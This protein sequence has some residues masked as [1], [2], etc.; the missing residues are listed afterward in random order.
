MGMRKTDEKSPD[1]PVTDKPDIEGG[2]TE[3]PSNVIYINFQRHQHPEHI[4]KPDESCQRPDDIVEKVR[5]GLLSRC[6][7]ASARLDESERSIERSMIAV[8]VQKGILKPEDVIDN[9]KGPFVKTKNGF[10]PLKEF[11][12]LKIDT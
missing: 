2:V 6:K 11:F 4:T 8:L 12:S 9:G 5:A 1:M 7:V 3:R 10:I